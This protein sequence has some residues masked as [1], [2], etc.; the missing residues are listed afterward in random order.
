SVS[1]MTEACAT[2]R[3]VYLYDTGDGITSMKRNPFLDGEDEDPVAE[4]ASADGTGRRGAA[5]WLRRFNR[6]HL[7]AWVY[8]LGMRMGPER[9]T[10]DIRIVQQLLVDSDRA[11]WL[12]DGHPKAPPRPLDD[13]PRAVAR[14]RELFEG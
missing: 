13:M 9:L 12:G 10:R 8:R 7:R 1:M 3:F 5:G 2:G 14:V 4:D 11:V 6:S